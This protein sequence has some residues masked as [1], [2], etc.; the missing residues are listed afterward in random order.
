MRKFQIQDQQTT[1]QYLRILVA[2]AASSGKTTF[3]AS[4]PK[5]L[6]IV[7]S[8]EGGW[9]TI[10]T[11]DR[12]LWW[13]PGVRP[14]VW[15]IE[16]AMSVGKQIGDVVQMLAE[17]EAH[18][19]A[20]AQKKAQFPWDTIVIDPLSIYTD[21]IVSELGLQNPGQD[22]RQLYGDLAN[23]LRSFFMRVHA[24]PAHIIWTSHIRPDGQLAIAGAMSDKIPA[25]CDYKFLTWIETNG[26]QVHYMLHTQP[27]RNWTFLGGR[28]PKLPSPTIPSMKL[29]LHWLGYPQKPASPAIPGYPQGVQ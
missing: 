5:P 14:E 10:R 24:L 19:Q 1:D 2:G 9:S 27:F 7:D 20:H 4:A 28:G 15:V 22:N 3:C 16:K 11:M 18:A 25:L 17:L 29:V 26:P 8:Q 6:F 12:S 23:H 21:R 13:N